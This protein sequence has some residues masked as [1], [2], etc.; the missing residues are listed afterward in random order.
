MTLRHEFSDAIQRAQNAR[1]GIAAGL[2]L[3]AVT[4]LHQIIEGPGISGKTTL[5]KSYAAALETQGLTAVGKTQIFNCAAGHNQQH[6]MD[7]LSAATGGVL[8][9]DNAHL[10][11]RDY[12]GYDP[13]AP[14][15]VALLDRATVVL[16][17]G[18]TAGLAKMTQFEPGLL[19]HFG[20][21]VA[22][23]KFTAAEIDAYNK[24]LAE[25]AR[26]DALS[27]EARADEDARRISAEAW[28]AMKKIDVAII[29]AVKP[30]K[31]VRFARK[32]GG[33]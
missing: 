20:T 3:D 22:T 8:L 23:K 24:K 13:I 4:Q 33:R 2:S 10:L 19:R 32:D 28:H 26:R 1:L 6:F 27:P 7:T 14:L 31:T 21:T 15:K 9:L 16:L 5:A 11:S 17:V 29:N 12:N 30:V 25:E 18:E